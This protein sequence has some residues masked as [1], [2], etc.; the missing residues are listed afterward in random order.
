MKAVQLAVTALK[1]DPKAKKAFRFL[2]GRKMVFGFRTMGDRQDFLWQMNEMIM[3][4]GDVAERAY[5]N[6]EN[7]LT[8]DTPPA[9]RAPRRRTC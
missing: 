6:T 8:D 4:R 9:R 5:Y 7:D 2:R 3:A 1:A